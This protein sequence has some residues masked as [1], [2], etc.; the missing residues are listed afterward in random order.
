MKKNYELNFQM[1]EINESAIEFAK[2]F[3]D[4][5][6]T[7]NFGSMYFGFIHGVKWQIEK[8][9]DLIINFAQ[10]FNDFHSGEEYKYKDGYIKEL[11][12]TYKKRKRY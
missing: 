5:Y 8:Q 6:E 3:Y 9:E 12:E 2:S 4:L 10:W 11:L 1:Q 7:S